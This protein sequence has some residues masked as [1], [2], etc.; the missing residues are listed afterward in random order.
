MKRM[1]VLAVTAVLVPLSAHASN[2]AGMSLWDWFVLLW[3][4]LA[5]GNWR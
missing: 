4:K 1:V 2:L 5:G 3:I